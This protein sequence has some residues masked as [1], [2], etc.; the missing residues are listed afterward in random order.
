V[1]QRR[2]LISVTLAAL[3]TAGTFFVQFYGWVNAQ[4]GNMC[5]DTSD[6]P[7]IGPV[8]QA[9][10]PL[11]FVTDAPGV[12]VIG[13]LSPFFEDKVH[14]A[15]FLADWALFTLALYGLWSVWRGKNSLPATT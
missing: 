14:P 8:L 7:C 5:G 10:L 4:Y 9:G 2:M 12:S 15:A 13:S 6:Q 1:K 11:P 3:M